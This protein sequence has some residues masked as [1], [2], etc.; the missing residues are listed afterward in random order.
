[1]WAALTNCFDKMDKGDDAAKCAQW[2][3][4]VKDKEMFAMNKLAMLYKA[5]GDMDKAAYYFREDLNRRGN[6]D[7]HSEQTVDAIAFLAQYY[8]AK[9]DLKLAKEYVDHWIRLAPVGVQRDEANKCLQVINQH[10]N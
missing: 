10:M 3:D 1:M 5:R 8:L 7:Q 9:R 4:R 6:K 2:V